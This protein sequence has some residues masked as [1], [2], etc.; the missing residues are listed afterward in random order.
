MTIRKRACDTP[1]S[2][3][4][5][6]HLRNA[7]SNPKGDRS[8]TNSRASGQAKCPNMMH[9]VNKNHF[10]TSSHRRQP[11]AQQ[12]RNGS[13]RLPNRQVQQEEDECTWQTH[14]NTELT[15]QETSKHNALSPRVVAARMRSEN[16][17]HTGLRAKCNC[18][19]TIDA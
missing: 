9:E 4:R 14:S 19:M 12:I 5:G 13:G 6:S 8:Q 7:C 18:Q 17:E 2:P 1:P 15:Q 16:C 3:P 10:E 11:H